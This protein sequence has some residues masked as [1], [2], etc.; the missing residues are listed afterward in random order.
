MHDMSMRLE[1]VLKPEEVCSIVRVLCGMLQQ[2]AQQYRLEVSHD[3][4]H[5]MQFLQPP[6]NIDASSYKQAFGQLV[7]CKQDSTDRV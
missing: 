6:A 3:N 5:S 7:A 2:C 1:S 4:S